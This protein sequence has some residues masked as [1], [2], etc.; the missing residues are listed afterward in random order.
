MKFDWRMSTGFKQK[1]VRIKSPSLLIGTSVCAPLHLRHVRTVKTFVRFVTNVAHTCEP[2]AHTRHLAC[3]PFASWCVC[4]I[5]GKR[6]AQKCKAVRCVV[7]R[8]HIYRPKGSNFSKI[9]TV[10]ASIVRLLDHFPQHLGP[11]RRFC[12]D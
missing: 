8:E 2:R 1:L 10:W 9:W 7:L 12:T 6:G 3:F 5:R 4:S 11:V